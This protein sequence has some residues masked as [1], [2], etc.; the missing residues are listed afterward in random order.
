MSVET[1][2][3]FLAVFPPATVV[4]RLAD[5]LEAVRQ[6][7]DGVG[8][9][10]SANVHY[11]LRFLGDL[12]PAGV[13]AAQR[14]AVRAAAAARPFRVALGAPGIFPD[15]RRPR[16]LWL[17]AN[18][19]AQALTGL[20]RAL[21]SALMT[22][23]FSRADKPFAPHLTLGRVRDTADGPK[24]AARFL[25]GRYPADA[26]EVRELVVVKSTLDPRGAL[27]EPLATAALG[28]VPGTP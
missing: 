20:S 26:F 18:E 17:G 15:A 9:V 5:A 2:R 10:K 7:G 24:V 3:T 13:E 14:A 12:E 21:E 19:G 8:W 4:E 1:T 23:G 6:P 25:A 16:V 11:T 28:S 22:E 27:Y